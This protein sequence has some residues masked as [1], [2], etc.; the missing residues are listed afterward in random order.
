MYPKFQQAFVYILH[1]QISCHS[2]LNF[3][4]IIQKFSEM[5]YTFCIHFVYISCIHLVQFL[6]TKCIH[7]FR[8]GQVRPMTLYIRIRIKIQSKNLLKFCINLVH[9]TFESGRDFFDGWGISNFYCSQWNF[10]CSIVWFLGVNQSWRTL[11]IIAC[12]K[13]ILVMI[14]VLKNHPQNVIYVL[15][16]WNP[17]KGFT[18]ILGVFS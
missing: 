4:Y 6:Y 17:R 16:F 14:N 10:C 1:T 12:Y 5:W 15:C 13:T 8:V 7:D 9:P 2:S 3:I 18:V 11:W